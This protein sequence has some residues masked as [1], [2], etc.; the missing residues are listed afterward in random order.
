MAAAAAAPAVAASF[1]WTQQTAGSSAR[2]V[3]QP[4]TMDAGFTGQAS[5]SPDGKLLAYASDRAET[6]NLDIWL[7]QMSSGSTVRFTNEPG[8]ED[9]PRFSAD[10]T[11]IYYRSEEN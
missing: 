2:L 1:W 11:R 10:G 6:G 4:L 3:L 7:R 8:L 5:F 9:L